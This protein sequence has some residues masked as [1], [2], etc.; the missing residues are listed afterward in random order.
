MNKKFLEY[1]FE[2]ELY[3]EN[4]PQNMK[5]FIGFCNKRGVKLTQEK[6]EEFERNGWFY[7]IFR[8]KDYEN[9]PHN[10][11]IT[12]DF[13]PK[14]HSDFKRLLNEE[15]I[16]LPQE[17]EFMEFSRFIDKQARKRKFESYYSTFQIYHIIQLLEYNPKIHIESI[18]KD[19]QKYVHELL[20]LLIAVQIY[21]PYGRSDTRYIKPNYS[22]YHEKLK[23]YT[24]K[25]VLKLINA[26]EDDLYKAYCE[27]CNNLEDL[28]GNRFAIQ[29]WKN[30]GWDKK[31]NCKGHTRLG[32][33]YLQWA[34]MLKKCIEHHIGREIFDV[35]E[36][37]MFWDDIK[38]NIPSE[39]TGRNIRGCRNEDFTNDITGEYEFDNSN[40]RLY[41]LANYLN[42]N[43]HPKV[44]VLVEGKTEELMLPKFFNFYICDCDKLGIEIVNVGGVS[45]FYGKNIRIKDEKTRRYIDNIVTSFK[46]LINYNLHKWQT[47]P[48]FIGDNENKF[49]QHV[50]EGR[51][52]DLKEF[53][54][55]YDGRD[56]KEIE[57][58][59]LEP[60]KKR[61][62]KMIEEW[63][64]VWEHDFELDT[65]TPEELQAAINE[66][67]DTKFS[68]EK[69]KN[70]YKHPKNGEKG[71]LKSLGDE[72]D[73]NKIRINEKAFE[74]LVDYYNE[75]HDERIFDREI[76]KVLDKITDLAVYNPAPVNTKHSM[77]NM[78][79]L[80]TYLI[81]G[82]DIYK[83]GN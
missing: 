10:T 4:P 68:L 47:I 66:V 19:Y 41:Y 11:F 31:K 52:F 7:P 30:I 49:A 21:A 55:R 38:N 79:E 59:Y 43:Y 33:E 72:I 1:Y 60:D 27:I 69:I 54:E 37:D 25:E 61:N 18:F 22:N 76:F 82:K 71:G 67:C 36:I 17:Y 40:K 74:N 56:M 81:N 28:L 50:I 39:E 35:D 26:E 77:R 34:M 20:D 51:V 45:N 53:F 9:K 15:Y 63:K 5:D 24:L 65:Y 73:R 70:I 23:D 83:R 75:T 32:I 58:E 13:H 29:L 64:H 78:H 14:Y 2:K 8:V 42:I 62:E 80:G 46:H 16:F 48:Y 12:L 3:V 6:L 44:T 57:G